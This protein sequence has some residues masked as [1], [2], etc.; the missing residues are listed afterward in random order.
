MNDH[1]SAS[2]FDEV[3]HILSSAAS[4]GIR[5]GLERAQRLLRRLGHPQDRW[6]AL[7]VVGTNGKGSTCAFL[8]S[9]LQACG[10]RTALYT[11]PHLESPEERLLIDGEP[12]S[13]GAWLDA[14]QRVTSAVG[15][16]ALLAADPPSYF[17]LVTAAAFL[18]A[19]E[20][21]AEVAVVEA[22]LGGRLDATNLLGDVL[23]SVIASISMDHMDFLGDTIEAIAGEKFAVAR[24]G[25][26]ACL[27]GDDA[28]LVPLFRSFCER[29]GAL[30]FVVSEEAD[31]SDARVDEEGCT[32]DFRAPGLELPGVR[33]RMIGRYQ[34]SNAALALSSLS[35]V[36]EALP[37]LSPAGILRGME[38]ARWPGR[39]E[40]LSRS[41]L[42]ALDGAHNLDGMRKLT[43][44]VRELWPDRDLA[45][46]YAT[47]RDK[48]YMGCLSSL[49]ALRPVLYAT[50]V[51]G[52]D[53]SL[54]VDELL[55]ASRGYPWNG[56][57]HAFGSPL[58]AARVAISEHGAV[59]I[60]GSLYLIGWIRPRL[61]ETLEADDALR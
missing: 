19:S 39:M 12:R 61:R 10:Y 26:P 18:L 43:Q 7:H 44:S 4:A 31:V 47:M 34:L 46:V 23:C 53:R 58:D 11:S 29:V 5:P 14:A 27:L 36:M 50:T 15:E 60:C 21:G 38:D 3:E 17:E 25:V 45:V 42:V 37:R 9:C 32:F 30:P 20:G 6:P 49:S 59:L 2:T 13:A 1:E 55:S 52:M 22:G 57:P 33:T 24:R 56:V 35:C 41:P 8:A 16:D 48:D 51:P 54:P 28:S 40:L